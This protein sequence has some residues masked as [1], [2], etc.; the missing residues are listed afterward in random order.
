MGEKRNT[1]DQNPRRCPRRTS[2]SKMYSTKIEGHDLV[3]LANSQSELAKARDNFCVSTN[4][5]TFHSLDPQIDR[6]AA[7]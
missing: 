7:I 2:I 4:L 1:R 6:L 5:S 3:M